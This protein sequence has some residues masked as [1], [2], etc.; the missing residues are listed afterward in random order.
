MNASPKPVHRNDE[1]AKPLDLTLLFY[2]GFG[3]RECKVLRKLGITTYGALIA[4][5][6]CDLVRV[7]NCGPRT[8]KCITKLAGHLRDHVKRLERTSSQ[9][10]AVNE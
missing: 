10:R 6:Y 8:A 9:D 5:R 4:L 3:V 7:P 1:F 2:S